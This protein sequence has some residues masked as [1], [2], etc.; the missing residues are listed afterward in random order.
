MRRSSMVELLSKSFFKHMNDSN[1]N[2]DEA[3]YSAIL[4]DM[5]DAGMTPPQSV[6][7]DPGHFKC[8]S[9]EYTVN[10][11]DSEEALYPHWSE[12]PPSEIYYGLHK[13]GIGC[14]RFSLNVQDKPTHYWLDM[15]CC[16]PSEIKS[17]SC[18][19]KE[20]GYVRK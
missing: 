3:M 14:Y 16:T 4:Q 7:V 5:E 9:F 13:F 10:E 2:T 15:E 17:Y 11:W 18:Y 1:L 12:F 8:D 20:Q 19:L 6:R